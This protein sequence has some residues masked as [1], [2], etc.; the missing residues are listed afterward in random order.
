MIA[1]KPFKCWPRVFNQFNNRPPVAPTHVC[2]NYT[3][4]PTSSG[5][6][7]R[8]LFALKKDNS[9]QREGLKLSLISSIY[10]LQRFDDR[11]SSR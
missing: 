2:I 1:T 6:G 7:I 5:L 9:S 4:L 8:R 11:L 3:K 10:M